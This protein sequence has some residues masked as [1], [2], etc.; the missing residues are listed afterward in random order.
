MLQGVRLQNVWGQAALQRREE[1]MSF[2]IVVQ[3]RIIGGQNYCSR[4]KIPAMNGVWDTALWGKTD[5]LEVAQYIQHTSTDSDPYSQS[6]SQQ[7]LFYP[8]RL[9]SA[10]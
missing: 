8:I 5:M 7:S 1:A 9:V 10:K 2:H 6:P 4:S 3:C